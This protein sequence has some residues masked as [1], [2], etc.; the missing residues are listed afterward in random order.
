[1]ALYLASLLTLALML[2]WALCQFVVWDMPSRLYRW[3]SHQPWGKDPWWERAIEWFT[4]PVVWFLIL[5]VLWALLVVLFGRPNAVLKRH[6]LECPA[7]GARRG[8]Q[9]VKKAVRSFWQAWFQWVCCRYGI[10][11]PRPYEAILVL[12][13]LGFLLAAGACVLQVLAPSGRFLWASRPSV[14]LVVF[15]VVVGMSACYRS[16]ARLLIQRG[17]LNTK[18]AEAELVPGKK[19]AKTAK[20]NIQA[21]LKESTEEPLLGLVDRK[22]ADGSS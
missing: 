3:V 9:R 18:T 6:G 7:P 20:D 21:T 8:A 1:M 4:I 12:C 17:E 15:F 13:C 16:T 10:R 19:T 14:P 11:T 22:D 5:I 2:T